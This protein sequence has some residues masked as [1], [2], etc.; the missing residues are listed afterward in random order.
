MKTLS[1]FL[2]CAGAV[3]ATGC[4]KTN[5]V[6]PQ[7]AAA[8]AQVAAAPTAETGAERLAIV[9]DLASVYRFTLNDI[10]GNPVNLSRYR[11][12]KILIVNTASYCGYTPQF[13][14]LE[15]LATTYSSRLV[16]LGFPCNDFG[17]QDPGTDG[18]INNFCTGTYGV[19]F[20]MFS[21][22]VSIGATATP[23]YRFLGDR[24]QNGFTSDRPDWNFC[25]YLIDEQGHVMGFYRSAV[26][27]TDPAL[28]AAIV[29]PTGVVGA[30]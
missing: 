19:T 26:T 15:A 27:P 14:G 4:S 25:K 12:K 11:G 22:I 10:Y 3:M 18:Q 5:D 17:G 23:L 7:L 1:A 8:S 16:V 30:Y 6:A 9:K 13:T 24:T 28:I 2:L 20:P 29:R 21:R